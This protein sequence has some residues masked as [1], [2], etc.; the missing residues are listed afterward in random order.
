MQRRVL[1]VLIGWSPILMLAALAALTY[2]L[3]AQVHD[4]GTRRDA[5][6][7]HDPDLIVEG[8]RAV[9]LDKSGNAVQVLSAQSA[10]HFPDDGTVEF[11]EP[12]F[13]MKQPDRPKFSVEAQRG[14]ISGN[15]EDA[16]FEGAVRATRDA[17]GAQDDDAGP[18]SLTT[19]FLHVI[20]KADRA[21][22]DRPVTIEEPRGIIH[23]DGLT[24]D[25]QAKTLK[26]HSKVRGTIAPRADSN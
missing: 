16:Y 24:L 17:E 19:E 13:T 23:A 18:I 20:P 8:V 12:R 9:E 6:L 25:N 5:N 26:L 1:D 22:T 7:R 11:D 2:W 21:E 10:R 3:D 4:T 14:R 15:R